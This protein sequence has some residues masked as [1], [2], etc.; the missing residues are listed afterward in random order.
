MNL[1]VD[2]ERK[3]EERKEKPACVNCELG[4]LQLSNLKPH[5]YNIFDVYYFTCLQ[6]SLNI[7]FN[8][9][10]LFVLLFIS[11][12]TYSSFFLF[13]FPINIYYSSM[14]NILNSVGYLCFV[15][16]QD[17][18]LYSYIKCINVNHVSQSKWQYQL[19]GRKNM[20]C[21][22]EDMKLWSGARTHNATTRSVEHDLL[23][24]LNGTIR[25][26]ASRTS[27]PVLVR[28]SMVILKHGA[29]TILYIEI[30]HLF[31]T[32]LTISCDMYNLESSALHSFLQ[33]YVTFFLLPQSISSWT[34]RK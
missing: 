13:I 9:L 15:V 4:K 20:F 22:T 7:T 24:R 11:T 34:S 32:T 1:K 17:K 27:D 6:M 10:Q 8:F 19:V 12:F 2:M 30:Y 3:G 23:A 26:H 16:K 28:S 18:S 25:N 29:N 14:Y 5:L 33:S 31:I 21:L